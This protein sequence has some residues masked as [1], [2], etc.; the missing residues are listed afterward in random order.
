MILPKILLAPRQSGKTTF[1]EGLCSQLHHDPTYYCH[2]K[3]R[4]KL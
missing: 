4:L 1:I 2:W 3:G